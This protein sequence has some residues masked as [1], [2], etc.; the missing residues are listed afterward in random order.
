MKAINSTAGSKLTGP[1]CARSLSAHSYCVRKWARCPRCP[2][3]MATLTQSAGMQLQGHSASDLFVPEPSAADD[4]SAQ[5]TATARAP[6]ASCTQAWHADSARRS[7]P[8][9]N[10]HVIQHEYVGQRHAPLLA[11]CRGHARE[12][13]SRRS[14]VANQTERK[15][16]LAFVEG[17]QGRGQ[18][19]GREFVAGHAQTV[20]VAHARAEKLLAVGLAAQ[21]H[22]SEG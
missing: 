19:E 8:H 4:G 17:V 10:Q 20:E 3:P 5:H 18:L 21:F 13:Q 11:P 14:I 16:A 1:L 22:S 7:F 9:L 6:A 12:V 15:L 2:Y